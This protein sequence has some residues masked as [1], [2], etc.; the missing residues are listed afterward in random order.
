MFLRKRAVSG[1]VT[2]TLLVIGPLPMR[3]AQDGEKENLKTAI[4]TLA[5]EVRVML[6]QQNQESVAVVD[7]VGS[8]VDSNFGPGLKRL[9]SE[10]LKAQKVSVSETASYTIKGKYAAVD[11]PDERNRIVMRLSVDVFSSSQGKRGTYVANVRDTTDIAKLAGVTAS[12]QP[13]DD[14]ET[15]N[16]KI[17]DSKKEPSVHLDGTRI[18]TRPDSPFAVEL[19]VKSQPR[20]PKVEKG[21]AFVDIQRDEIYAVRV[22]NNTKLEAAISLNIDGLDVFTFSDVKDDKTGDTRYK[23]FIVAPGQSFTITG[24]HKTNKKALAFLV[25]E[26]GK[27]AA[28][29]MKSTGEVGVLTLTFR[30]ASTHP[31][32][33]PGDKNSTLSA[34]TNETGFGPEQ[35]TNL[36][37]V[38]RTIGAVSDVVIVRY[39]R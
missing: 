9:L 14:A 34:A 27:G 3:A 7:F 26:Y 37:E 23:H 21:Q 24:W 33:L 2:L 32:D 20:Q 12:L 5:S 18:K 6:K 17:Q 39:T 36:Q 38:A 19:L 25:A 4:K 35:G 28:S 15:R 1:F 22:H 8:V 10:E 13:R 16:Q 31:K 29:Q 30:P 11:D